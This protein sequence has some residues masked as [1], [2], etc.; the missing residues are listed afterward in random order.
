MSIH[1][2]TQNPVTI[3]A[4]NARVFA[5]LTSG[6]IVG[7]I[8]RPGQISAVLASLANAGVERTA[9]EII[10]ES[11]LQSAGPGFSRRLAGWFAV[12]GAER[13]ILGRYRTEVEAGNALI[14]IRNVP[15]DLRQRASAALQVSGGR[16]IHDFGRF[17]VRVVA[18]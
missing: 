4:A 16:F 18:P 2:A 17:T 1:I 12:I 9:I 6:S 3:R 10:R 15:A 13:A 5:L 11:G 7:L 8:D 14:V